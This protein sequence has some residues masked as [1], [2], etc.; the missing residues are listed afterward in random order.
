MGARSRGSGRS[1]RTGLAWLAPLLLLLAG[2]SAADEQ[3]ID[4]IAAQVGGEVVLVSEVRQMSAPLEERMRK[5]GLPES[6]FM[7]MRADVLER[8]I[9]AKLVEDVVKRLEL[10]A[11]PEEVDQAIRGIASDT[12][13]SMDQLQRSVASHGLTFEEYR[14]KITSEIERSKV[15]GA[16][17]RSRVHIEPEEVRAVYDARFADQPTGGEEVHLKHLLVAAGPQI[18]RDHGTAC[19]L[20]DGAA[21]RIA[22]GESTFGEMVG[23]MSDA[24]RER[25]GD[26]GW[27]HENELAAWMAPTV[28]QLQAGE[29]SPP[30][31][32]S[33]GCNLLMLVERRSFERVTFEKAAPA[34]ENQ[35]FRQKMEVEYT[36]W[37]ETLREQTYIERKGVF[38]EAERLR[39]QG[40]SPQQ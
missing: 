3:L 9:E 39:G 38:A 33:F 31:E 17:V 25:G 21:Q 16:M 13:I 29:L 24:N 20:V 19:A 37:T 18:H 11:T 26:L 32:T 14:A 30:I 12:G 1:R 5:A 23:E 15:L 40:P 7:R 2:S 28:V 36:A 8:L 35:L 27:I 22:R 4:G 10:G 6:E 34:I